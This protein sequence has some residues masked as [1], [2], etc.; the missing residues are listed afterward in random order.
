[1]CPIGTSIFSIFNFTQFNHVTLWDMKMS[2]QVITM[3]RQLNI[4]VGCLNGLR[5]L[6]RILLKK[7][8]YIE[9]QTNEDVT[10]G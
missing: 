2:T 4:H 9:N 10:C 5:S 6:V 8:S 7:F 1:M 3:I